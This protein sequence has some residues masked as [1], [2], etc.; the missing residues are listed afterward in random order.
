MNSKRWSNVTK[1]IVASVLAVLAIILLALFRTMI[2]PTIVAF[3]L[4]FILGYPV[5]WIQRRTGWG[6]GMIVALIYVALL[7]L[8]VLAPV[9]FIPRFDN[10]SA[11]LLETLVELVDTLQTT[12]NASLVFGVYEVS[13][14][15]I[16]QQAGNALQ[17]LL[18]LSTG[19]PLSI[20]RGVT[21]GL[22]TVI[23]VL[24]LN[25]WLLKDLQKLQRLII[26]QVPVDYQEEMRQLGHELGQ[27]WHA[28]LR[29]QLVLGLT[30]GAL[31]WLALT[32][33]GM[34]NAGGLALLAAFMEFLP[35]IGP[36]ISGFIGTMVA[37]FQG[38]NWFFFDN[39][40]IF[41]LLVLL[42]YVIIT[43]FESIYL[44]PKLVGGRVQLHPAVTFVGVIS[45][46]LVFGVLGVLLA[47]PTIASSKRILTY[48]YRKMFDM[49][50]FEPPDGNQQGVRIRGLV[51]GRKIEGLIFDLDGTLTQLDWSAAEWV[52]HHTQW[53]NRLVPEERRK[54][55][56]RRAMI[57]LESLT[58]FIVQQMRR[59]QLHNDLRRLEPLFDRLRGYPSIQNLELLPDVVETLHTLRQEYRLSL[60]STRERQGVEDFLA[61]NGLDNGLLDVVITREDIRNLVPHSEALL[62]AADSMGLTTNNL[63]VVSDSD[64]NLRSGS[65]TE[66]ATAGVLCGLSQ[67]RDLQSADIILERTSELVDWL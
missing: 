19:N 11:S 59:L 36:G 21:T 26:E 15:N 52:A 8:L 5:T 25:F 50:P 53:L 40:I 18:V 57:A 4:A 31:T 33:V 48:I 66:M 45:G 3:L 41:A 23:Y 47:T 27:I 51:A 28:F 35:T 10:V 64:V 9:I 43:Q 39:N 22:L 61:R 42:I 46:A 6:R 20:F 29:G 1:I 49:E 44:I 13:L 17:N 62:T 37:L 55:A 38:S 65:A 54:H 60:V 67:E 16:L 63:L 34:P 12:A 32:I 2:A 30:V 58:T 24:V 7:A 56:T 14:D